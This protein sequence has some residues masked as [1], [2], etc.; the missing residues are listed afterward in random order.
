[1]KGNRPY[2]KRSSL[3][4]VDQKCWHSS[5]NRGSHRKVSWFKV[6]DADFVAILKVIT[7]TRFSNDIR[8][9][10][11]F[12]HTGAVEAMHSSKLKYLPKYKSNS[13]LVTIIL[14][15]LTVIEHNKHAKT[16]DKVFREY[17]AYSRAQK[18]YVLKKVTKRDS[19]G[20]K[21]GILN[22]VA[23][24]VRIIRNCRLTLLVISESQSLRN[25]MAPPNPA[26]KS[27]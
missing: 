1:M 5:L 19:V 16:L 23:D 11:K 6:E 8:H 13:M 7:D 22:S 9:C 27:C 2:P 26:S 20:L 17:P 24:N 15:I 10:S 21:K 25:F 18:K 14:T 4:K 12:L 3:G